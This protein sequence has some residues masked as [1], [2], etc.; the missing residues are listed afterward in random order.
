MNAVNDVYGFAPKP[1]VNSIV[2]TQKGAY[3]FFE[4]AESIAAGKAMMAKL[5]AAVDVVCPVMDSGWRCT[6]IE[7]MLN[8]TDQRLKNSIAGNLMF[9]SIDSTIDKSKLT[10]EQIADNAIPR[11]LSMSD[12]AAIGHSVI[13]N[14][15]TETE[16]QI[17]N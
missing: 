15:V 11:G 14:P 4:S 6:D 17:D 5:N 10:D 12:V 8:T 16:I 2:S 1:V 7:T 9:H 13:D 3:L